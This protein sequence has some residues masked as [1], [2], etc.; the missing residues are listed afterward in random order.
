METPV[1]KTFDYKG[2]R[3]V[4]K[5]ATHG[6]CYGC[7]FSDRG[8]CILNEDQTD[9][10]HPCCIL[11]RVDENDVIFVEESD[12]IEEHKYDKLIDFVLRAMAIVGTIYLIGAIFK[13]W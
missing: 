1:N 10:Q 13:L 9:E 12:I 8:T 11:N 6:T 4:V 2:T 3:Y 7:G 5:L